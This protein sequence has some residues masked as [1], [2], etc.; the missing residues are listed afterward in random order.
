MNNWHGQLTS[1]AL[2][3]LNKSYLLSMA[4]PRFRIVIRML[5]PYHHQGA[6]SMHKRGTRRFLNNKLTKGRGFPKAWLG[7]NYYDGSSFKKTMVVLHI[8]ESLTPLLVLEG[9]PSAANP[10]DFEVP[11]LLTISL[12]P[13]IIPPSNGTRRISPHLLSLGTRPICLILC[14]LAAFVHPSRPYG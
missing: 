14:M 13:R 12:L 9:L 3:L 4:A 1:L 5:C 10:L 2:R 7:D 11:N 8:L 6:S